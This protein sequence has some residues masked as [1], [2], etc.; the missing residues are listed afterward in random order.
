MRDKL[1]PSV[2]Y[3]QRLG[4][5]YMDQIFEFAHWI[6]EQ[7]ADIG[8]EVSYSAMPS[9]CTTHEYLDLHV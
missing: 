8:L 9:E 2:T 3:L 6:F 4:P 5:Q 1:M 7:D